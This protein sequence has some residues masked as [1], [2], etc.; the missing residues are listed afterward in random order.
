MKSYQKNIITIGLTLV[1]VNLGIQKYLDAKHLSF[2]GAYHDIFMFLAMFPFMVVI[3]LI[4]SRVIHKQIKRK[5]F[6]NLL[7]GF[8]LF[9]ILTFSGMMIYDACVIKEDIIVKNNI[10]Y[11]ANYRPGDQKLGLTRSY[12]EVVNTF[13][14]KK[15]ASFDK[16]I[17]SAPH[18]N[19]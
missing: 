10:T 4:L 16:E 13:F 6:Q 3:Y 17:K 1:I 8:M 19:Q 2:R 9:I 7:R 12:F 15:T 14:H 11:T 5:I 18:S